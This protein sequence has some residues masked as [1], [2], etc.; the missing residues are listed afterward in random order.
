MALYEFEHEGR[1]CKLGKVFEWEQPMGAP[2]LKKCPQCGGPVKK[3]ISAPQLSFPKTDAE[4]K[5]QG[6]TKLVRREKGVYE[7]V[8]AQEG[9]SRMVKL[10]DES[11]YPRRARRKK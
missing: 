11:T 3:L 2:P 8:T 10:G 5:S 9:E 7:N 4:L 6:F 1:A